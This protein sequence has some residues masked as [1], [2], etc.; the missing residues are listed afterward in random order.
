MIPPLA[1][2]M[3]PCPTK[4]YSE[5][6]Y[7]FNYFF[8]LYLLGY[9]KMMMINMLDLWSL[10]SCGQVC[11]SQCHGW[12]T[13]TKLFSLSCRFAGTA[14]C[15]LTSETLYMIRVDSEVGCSRM[16][17][18]NWNLFL[19]LSVSTVKMRIIPTARL[20]PTNW[21]WLFRLMSFYKGESSVRFPSFELLEIH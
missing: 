18:A 12:R 1:L 6:F 19:L 9:G 3:L 4:W 21:R 10:C 15:E 17:S 16:T 11:A 5:R 7:S 20:Y 14:Q 13:R 2:P 8:L